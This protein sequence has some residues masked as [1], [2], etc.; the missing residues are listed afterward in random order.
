D[1][2]NVAGGNVFQIPGNRLCKLNV[3]IK[4]V[5]QLPDERHVDGS[6]HDVDAIRADVG[7]DLNFSHDHRFFGKNTAAACLRRDWLRHTSRDLYAANTWLTW[8]LSALLENFLEHVDDFAGIGALEF[9]EFADHFRRRHIH[10]FNHT[11]K[12][13]DNI[14]VLRH[15]QAGGFWQGQNVYRARAPLKIGD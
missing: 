11:G 14:G 12:L 7:S 13:P 4:F 5:D 10:L 1:R 6:R 9:D 15:K 3:R 2:Q 8:R